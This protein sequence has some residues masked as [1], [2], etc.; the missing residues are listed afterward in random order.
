VPMSNM[1]M[2]LADRMGAK[3]VQNFGDATGRLDMI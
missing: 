2:S 3:G 1:L